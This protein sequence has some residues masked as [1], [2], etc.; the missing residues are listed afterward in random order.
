MPWYRCKLLDD[1]KSVEI[2]IDVLT[3]ESKIVDSAIFFLGYWHDSEEKGGGEP[4][5]LNYD[6]LIDWGKQ[7]HV[8]TFPIRGLKLAENVVIQYTGYENRAHL[9][10]GEIYWQTKFTVISYTKHD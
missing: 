7:P 2:T 3:N 1:E 6:N 10:R 5:R 8:S 4:F 9:D